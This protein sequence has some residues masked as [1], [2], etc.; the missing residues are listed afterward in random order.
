MTL[1]RI[2]GHRM[3]TGSSGNLRELVGTYGI[4]VVLVCFAGVLWETNGS[5]FASSTN[6][7]N[8]LVQSSFVGIVALGQTFAL[9]TGGIDL[10]VGSVVSLSGIMAASIA[11]RST[12]STLLAVAAILV[13]GAAWGALQAIF[14]VYFRIMPF[15]V[16]L[17]GLSVLEGFTLMLTNGYPVNVALQD[18]SFLALGQTGVLGVPLPAVI[19]L[20]LTVVLFLILKITPFGRHLYALGSNETT[21]RA[22]GISIERLK[23][24]VYMISGTLAALAGLLLTSWVSGADPLAGRGYE[25]TSIAAAVIGGT[26]LFGGAG[27]VA[28]TFVGVVFLGTVNNGLNLLAV[29]AYLQQMADGVVLMVAV[30]LQRFRRI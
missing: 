7:V 4:Y 25:L 30:V 22:V 26:S 23:F 17:A 11:S 13:A 16:T 3:P 27:G 14:I 28:G 10:S 18:K 19:F 2:L 5:A 29:N 12:D 1:S 21:A 8:I 6:L 24:A 15:L 20:L 9:I